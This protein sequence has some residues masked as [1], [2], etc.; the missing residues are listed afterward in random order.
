MGLKYKL[1]TGK[2]TKGQNKDNVDNNAFLVNVG[3]LEEIKIS[4]AA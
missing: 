2:G 4:N 1:M 3:D